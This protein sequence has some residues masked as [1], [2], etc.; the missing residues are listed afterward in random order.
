MIGDAC[1][2]RLGTFRRWVGIST[3]RSIDAEGIPEEIT[4]EP[5]NRDAMVF[6]EIKFVWLMIRFMLELILRVLY[7][8]RSHAE[9]SPF[10]AATYSYAAP[11]INHIISTGGN[12]AADADEILEQLALALDFIRFH[13]GECTLLVE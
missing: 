11:L 2:E 4:A 8:L 6:N 9:Q 1:S 5:L 7:R 13:C 10:D 3:L 12:H